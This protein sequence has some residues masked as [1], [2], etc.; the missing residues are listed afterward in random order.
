MGGSDSSRVGHDVGEPEQQMATEQDPSPAMS[1]GIPASRATSPLRISMFGPL[2]IERPNTGGLIDVLGPGDLG[3]VKPK[4]LLEI[5]LLARGHPVRKDVLIEALWRGPA[6]GE[7]QNPT[8]TLESYVSVLR[9]HLFADRDEARR[10]LVTMNGAY[11]FAVDRIALDLMAFDEAM[12]R[13]ERHRAK[14]LPHLLHAGSLATGDLLEDV[15]EA[16]WLEQERELA[17]DRVARLHLLIAAD[18]LVQGDA[19]GAARHGEQVLASRPYSEEAFQVIMLAEHALGHSEAAR[20]AFERCRRLLGDELGLDCTT[21]TEDLGAAIDAGAPPAALIAARWPVSAPRAA[22]SGRRG[23]RRDPSRTLPFVGRRDELARAREL[24]ELAARGS[25]QMVVVRGRSGMGRSAF[26][27]ELEPMLAGTSESRVGR[28]AY[29]PIDLERPGVPLAAAI[30]RALAGTAGAEAARAYA[31]APFVDTTDATLHALRRLVIDH[32]PMTLLLDD[33]QWADADA[34]TALEWLGR[35]HPDVPLAVV[36]TMRATVHDAASPTVQSVPGASGVIELVPLEASP[37][38]ELRGLDAALIRATGGVPALLADSWRW[39]HAGGGTG[40]S[41]SLRDSV[42]RHVRGLGNPYAG[43]LR[44]A[45]ALPEPF[46]PEQLA[47]LAIV[48]TGVVDR[49]VDELCRVD[50]FERH[51]RGVRFRA[52]LVRDVLSDAVTPRSA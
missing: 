9:K 7:P 3:G 26:L 32:G 4:E 44:T 50:L 24:C 42:L 20:R 33:L 47:A 36:A 46:T 40:P 25:F 13:S 8:A 28:A 2:R 22:V 38:T 14:R 35:N 41:P 11:R 39:I 48:P 34:I 18:L 16:P 52:T 21:D 12:A 45:A 17:R 30:V 19:A 1:D 49:L 43:L 23:D 51:G 6:G 29:T 31:G 37:A 15:H 5:L 27:N 10:T